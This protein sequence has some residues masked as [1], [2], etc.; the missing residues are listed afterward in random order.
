MK[1]DIFIENTEKIKSPYSLKRNYS[2]NMKYSK[3][4]LKEGLTFYQ[5]APNI[6]IFKNFYVK[7][8]KNFIL[9]L[10]IGLTLFVYYLYLFVRYFYLFFLLKIIQFKILSLL[11]YI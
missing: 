3:N 7:M 5:K 8:K 1:A 6:N 2:S 11:K 10:T 9:I 4:K